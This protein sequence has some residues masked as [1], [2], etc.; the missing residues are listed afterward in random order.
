MNKTYSQMELAQIKPL[1]LAYVGDSVYEVYV[2]THLI[3]KSGRS[4]V[5]HLHR[6]SVKFVCCAA[7]AHILSVLEP[8][9]TEQEHDIVRRGR[10]AH[11]HTV[12][13]NASIHDYRCATG[14][15]A[16]IGYTYLKGDTDRLEELLSKAI[17]IGQGEKNDR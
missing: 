7:Q 3:E 2:R 16:L 5:N 15:E 17:E 12:P 14:F 4:D 11:S 8:I 9:L 10:N 13:K 1:V 6:M